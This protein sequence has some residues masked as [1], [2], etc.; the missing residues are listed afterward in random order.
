[1]SEIEHICHGEIPRICSAKFIFNGIDEEYSLNQIDLLEFINDYIKYHQITKG[2]RLIWL[3]NDSKFCWCLTLFLRNFGDIEKGGMFLISY[4][5]F[6]LNRSITKEMIFLNDL[7]V[8]KE[9]CSNSNDQE[10]PKL[11]ETILQ[12]NKEL[13]DISNQETLVSKP[14]FFNIFYK[15]PLFGYLLSNIS[16]SEE[17][18]IKKEKKGA[19]FQIC[20]EKNEILRLKTIDKN[21]ILEPNIAEDDE[22]VTLIKL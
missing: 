3:S 5:N 7:L 10:Q 11:I 9:Y 14:E 4:H 2:N 20:I 12:K 15:M 6:F 19:I 8:F 16:T 1:M 21:E 17:E 13:F 22:S 18:I